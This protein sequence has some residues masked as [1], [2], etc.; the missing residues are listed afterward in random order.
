LTAKNLEENL[1][2]MGR[3]ACIKFDNI[4]DAVS[5]LTKETKVTLP[6]VNGKPGEPLVYPSAWLCKWLSEYSP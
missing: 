6:L 3:V 2:C 5:L 4:L 1:K